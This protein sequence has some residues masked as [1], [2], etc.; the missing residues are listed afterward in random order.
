[1][2]MNATMRTGG[3]FARVKPKQGCKEDTSNAIAVGQNGPGGI[4]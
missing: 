4:G 3:Y 1:V 2:D